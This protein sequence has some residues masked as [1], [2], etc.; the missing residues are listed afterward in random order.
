MN[1]NTTNNER[2]EYSSKQLRLAVVAIIL[3]SAAY[4]FTRFKTLSILP[5]I[6]G[7]LDGLQYY[8]WATMMFMLCATVVAPLWG[9]ISDIF[10]RK[11]VLVLL[12]GLMVIGDLVSASAPNIF[13]FIAGFAI[14]GLGG[15]GMQGVYFAVLGDLF[16]PDKRGK[17]GGMIL[18]FMSSVQLLLPITAATITKVSSW[19][20]VFYL[21]TSVYVIAIVAILLFI[22]NIIKSDANKKIDYAGT[23]ILAC[24]VVPFLLALSWGG[25]KY[26]WASPLILIMLAVSIGMFIVVYLYEKRIPDYAIISIRLLKNRSFVFACLVSVFM[27]FSMSAVGSYLSLFMQGVQGLSATVYSAAI[28][29]ASIAAIFAGGLAGWLMD[30]TKR[31]KWLLVM[32]PTSALTVC[33]IFGMIPAT[34]PVIYIL[35]VKIVQQVCGASFM[36]SINPLA[37]MAQIDAKDFGSGTGTL[38]FVTNL[39]NAIAPALLGSVMNGAYAKNIVANTASIAGSLTPAQIKTISNARVL[40]DVKSMTALGKT[41]GTNTALFD[42]TV[43][44]V[45]AS[46]H[47][48]ISTVFL[49]AAVCV[50]FSIVFAICVK[51]I[52]LDQIEFKKPGAP[53]KKQSA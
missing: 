6:A 48:S 46:L 34:T 44:S 51:E 18:M 11:R 26:P 50:F 16:K 41:F 30:K 2:T 25:S 39:G 14:C 29:P 49:I 13:V 23:I 3:A 21:T 33:V 53:A 24:A 38:N 20:N 42:Q 52:P 4:W 8:T 9:K 10:G 5:I 28:M 43:Q 45:R 22:P 36:P 31:Y 35:A 7:E 27:A 32:A 17:Y 1:E 15:G 12:L 37:A 40:I 47:G 19:R